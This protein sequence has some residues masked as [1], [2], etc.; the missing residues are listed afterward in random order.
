MFSQLTQK[1]R[2]KP[3]P[4][5]KPAVATWRQ[6]VKKLIEQADLGESKLGKQDCGPKLEIEQP[7]G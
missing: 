2:K 5:Y 4:F 7:S 1:K 6:P 3:C